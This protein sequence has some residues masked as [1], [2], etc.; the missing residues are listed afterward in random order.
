MRLKGQSL[1][2]GLPRNTT[3]WMIKDKLK[4][5]GLETVNHPVVKSG[6]APQVILVS[7]QQARRLVKMKKIKIN[8]GVVEIR[9]YSKYWM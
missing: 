5:M 2:G 4:Q 3:G 1:W 6:F 9:T 7:V 8:G